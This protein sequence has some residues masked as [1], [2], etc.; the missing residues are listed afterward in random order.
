M[1]KLLN[2]NF[3]ELFKSRY[4]YLAMLI[5]AAIGGGLTAAMYL[6]P[7][8]NMP[9]D[10]GVILTKGT[11]LGFAPGFST[12]ILPFVAAAT[13]AVLLDSQFRHGIVRNMLTCGHKRAEIFLANLITMSAATAIYFVCYQI[14]VFAVA[15]FAFGYE[16]YTLKAA[17]VSLSVMLVMLISI[18]T[19]LSLVLGNFLRNGTP[20]I[21]ILVV[22]YALNLSM[23]FGMFKHESRVLSVL[24]SAFPQGCLFDFSYA[25]IPDG[26]EK[27]LIISVV[28]ILV[29][30]VIGL[31]HFQKCDIK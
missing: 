19:V 2:T 7:N 20:A 9:E 17:F 13:V 29:F 4:F 8:Y 12:I 28:M 30:T 24:A 25:V 14:A 18:S 6:F 10:A 15:I 22:Q 1:I 11:I 16:G 5:C 21:I 31:V 23:L 3:H 26:I 27:N